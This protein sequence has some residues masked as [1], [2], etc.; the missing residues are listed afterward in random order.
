MSKQHNEHMQAHTSQQVLNMR[1]E[2]EKL[3]ADIQI[4]VQNLDQ[5]EKELQQAQ[6]EREMLMH[7][8]AEIRNEVESGQSVIERLLLEKDVLE[9]VLKLICS[10]A[11]T[12]RQLP[13]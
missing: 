2:M 4:K 5:R 11:F 1:E 3:R 6:L 9:Q 13:L 10:Y 8:M 7:E 12:A